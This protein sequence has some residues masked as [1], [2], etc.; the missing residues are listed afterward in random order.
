MGILGCT[1][2]CRGKTITTLDQ[3][4]HHEQI[5]LIYIQGSGLILGATFCAAMISLFLWSLSPTTGLLWWMA[6]IGAIALMRLVS[7]RRYFSTTEEGRSNFY[8][9][10]L[11]WVGTLMAGVVWG[12]WPLMF[13]DIY[14]K[15]ALLLISTLFAGMVAVS[16][17][18][19]RIYIPSFLSFSVPLVV[20][21]C[22]RHMQSGSDT[23]F[24]TGF[25]LLIFLGVNA[26]M[27]IKGNRQY[28]E[29]I[30]ARFENQSL[31]EKLAQEKHTAEQA[32]I[33]KNRFMAAASHDLR[34]PLH[35]LGMFL[36]TLRYKESDRGKLAII[37][38]MSASADALNGLFNS[39]LDVSKLDA[40]I[41]EVKPI[42][43]S[44]DT[45]FE[46]LHVQFKNQA[47]E[48]GLDLCTHHSGCFVYADAILLERVLRNLLSN[49]VL[50]TEQGSITLS[51]ESVD[52]K[53]HR[54]SVVDT[55]IGIP[56]QEKDNVFSEYHQLN[57]PER[58]R[59]KGL[60]LGLSI[61]SRICY[62]MG[63]NISMESTVG[64]GTRFDLLVPR[65]N[66]SKLADVPESSDPLTKSQAT[67]LVIDDEKSVLS[68]MQMMMSQW[69]CDVVLAESAKDA[70][71]TLALEHAQ[72]DLVI[73]DY[74]LRNN[75]NGVDAIVAVRE[76]LDREIP[77]I[78]VTGDTSPERLKEVSNTDLRL[79]HKPVNPVE[80]KAA[81]DGLRTDKPL[82][83]C[84]S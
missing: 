77:G 34:Q 48:R 13:Y 81:L 58:D 32:V 46:R 45:V 23:L 44:I 35:A 67:V 64:A 50:Y 20:P 66:K 49:A 61:V 40:E 27:T 8:W 54:I 24:L 22:V 53:H 72:P 70:I 4:I 11:F 26:S 57:N 17:A 16:A 41:I 12:M 7:V 59:N 37:E 68:A 71:R 19:G 1:K 43:M 6:T 82:V 14:S 78:I 76:A 28:R 18:S 5:R 31:L 2:P 29:L 52:D 65:G 30:K 83:E 55:G 36:E 39:I 73:S 33:A 79:L 47:A 42:H 63:V 25:L 69:G 80:I 62:L 3:K 51:C 21:L 56:E 84:A 74:R 15:E 9:G 10:P 60:G 38:D 75:C